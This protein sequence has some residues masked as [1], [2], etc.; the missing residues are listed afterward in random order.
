[1]TDDRI[2]TALYLDAHFRRLTAEGVF[3]TI[4]NRGAHASG[5]ILLKLYA[6]GLGARLLQQQRDEDGVLGWLA[7]F[8]GQTVEEATTDDYVRRALDR[9]P[10]LWVVEIESRDLRNPF[11]GKILS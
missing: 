3:Y 10:D 7:L 6:P 9:D 2:P 8:D 5:T 1:M 4:V 11:E